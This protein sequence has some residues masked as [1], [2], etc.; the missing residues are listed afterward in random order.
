MV[1]NG[2]NSDRNR[3]I[4]RSQVKE[5]IDGMG[6]GWGGGGSDDKLDVMKQNH[7]HLTI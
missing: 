2:R 7:R 4:K 1:L 6:G 3:F 5:S